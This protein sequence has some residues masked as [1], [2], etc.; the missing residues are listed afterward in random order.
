MTKPV[1]A[2][3]FFIVAIAATT[4]YLRQIESEYSKRIMTH[5]DQQYYSHQYTN[6]S[7]TNTNTTGKPESNIH[8]PHASYLVA[9]QK[10]FMHDPK[11]LLFRENNSPISITAQQAEILHE[12]NITSLNKNVIVS[13]NKNNK[14]NVRMTTDQLYLDH[15]KQIGKT[16]HEATI[17][18]GKGIMRGVG[19]EFNPHT[20][21]INFLNKVRG[22]Y[23]Y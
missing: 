18:H 4:F 19:L 9:E 8:S 10:T 3:I 23:E 21:Q 1:L 20:Q 7:L 14:Q 13:I 11:I 17:M 6:F 16:D 15:S 12:D 2:S 22:T 5:S